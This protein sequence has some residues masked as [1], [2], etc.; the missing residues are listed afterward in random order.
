MKCTHLV[1]TDW[2]IHYLRGNQEIVSRID[3]LRSR[4]VALSLITLAEIYEGIYNSRQPQA[5]LDALTKFLRGF[6]LLGLDVETCRAFG[7]ERGRLRALGRPIGDF[8]ILIGLTAR[9][10]G[11]TL[12]TNNRRHFELIKDLRIESLLPDTSA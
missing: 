8:D 12:L 3:E 5:S 7:R 6:H 10:N 4:G 9:Q 11:L 2:A 1:D